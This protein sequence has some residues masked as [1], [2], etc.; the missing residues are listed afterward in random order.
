MKKWT[1]TANIV[2][3]VVMLGSILHAEAVISIV[4]KI[5]RTGGLYGDTGVN[6]IGDV[7]N[8]RSICEAN[9]TNA[10]DV[11]GCDMSSDPGY[12]DNG[13]SDETDDFYTGDLIVRTNDLIEI[14]V[15]WNATQVNNPITLSSTLPS[16]GGKNYLGWDSLPSS[17]KDGS[18]ISDDGLTLTCVRTNDASIS[19]SEDSPFQIKVKAHA[20]NGLE[21]GP[22]SFSISSD[23]LE[24]KTDDTD[25][26][27]VTVTAKPMWNIQKA[28]ISSQEKQEVDGV[29][30]YIIRYAYLL[31]ADEVAGEN[32]TASAVLGNEALGKDFSLHFT[33]DVSAVSPN[34]KLIGCSI[35]GAGGS[36]PYPWYH[37]DEPEKSVGSLEGDLHVECSQNGG[38]G[39]DITIDYSGI[40][41]SLEHVP[42]RYANGGII[43]KTRL[44]IASGVVDIFVPEEDVKNAGGIGNDSNELDTNNTLTSFDPTSISG[45]SN[46]G[47]LEESTKDNS[48]IVPLIYRGPG[49]T[50]GSFHKYFTN[51]IDASSSLPDTTMGYR[52]ADGI[53]TPNKSFAAYLT[54]SNSGNKDFNESII[55]DVMDAN[56]YDVVDLTEDNAVRILS[57][58][59]GMTPIVEYAT[60]YVAGSWPPPLDQNNAEAVVDECK[61]PGVTW[62][63]TTT[64]ARTHGPITKV[65]VSLPENAGLPGHSSLSFTINLRV[66]SKDLSDV[67]IP[68]GT[69]LVNYS[70]LHDT[71]LNED[72]ADNW[73]GASRSLNYYPDA[74]TGGNERADRAIMMRAKVR[75]V[76]ELSTTIV[77]PSDEVTVHI[78]ST[79]TTDAVDPED[80]NVKVTEMLAPGLIYVVGSGS[81]GDPAFGTCDDLE[82]DDPLKA[83]C[84]P[85]HQ[86]LI[87]DLGERTANDPLPDI[88]YNFVVSAFT[89][90]GENS[91]YTIIS[92]PTDTS[93]TSIRT[94]NKNVSVNIP[95]SLFITK[96]VNTPFREVDEAPITFTSYA[97]NGSAVDLTDIDMIDILPFNGDGGSGRG[98]GFKFTVAS[99]KVKIR[100]K[101]PTSYH[102]TLEFSKAVGAHACNAGVTWY[103]TN[104]EPNKINISPTDESNQAG[105]DT[106]WCQGTDTGPDAAC[107]YGNA[108]VTAVRLTGPDISADQTCAFEIQLTPHGNHKGDVYTNTTSAFANGVTLPTLSNHVSA[109][110]PTTLLGDFVWLDY[111]ADGKQDAD[112]PGAAGITVKLLDGTDDSELNNTVTDADGKYVFEEL[113]ADTPY[114]VQAVIPAYYTFTAQHAG[115]NK[116]KDSD[117]DQATGISDAKSLN[118][119]QQYRH[120]DIGLLST[121]TISG[122]VY[123]KV[124]NSLMGN[125]VVNLY[126]DENDDGV[127]DE[128]DTLIKSQDISGVA[129]YEFT[130][131]FDGHYLVEVDEKP[132]FSNEYALLTDEVLEADV[133]GVS[134]EDKDFMYGSRPTSD[135]KTH[136]EIINIEGKVTLEDLTGG[137]DDGTVEKYIITSLPS[138]VSGTLYL[139]DDTAV[140]AGM[141]LTPAQAQGLQ[142]DPADGFIGNALFHYTTKDDDNLTDATPAT[143]TIPVRGLHISGHVFQD[144]DNNGNVDGAGIASPSGTQLYVS[145]LENDGTLIDSIL[146]NADGSYTFTIGISPDTSYHVVLT[147]TEDATAADLPSG[148]NNADG[149]QPKNT[150]AGTDGTVDGKLTVAV[151]RADVLDNDFGINHAPTADDKSE[152]SQ[153][154]PGSDTQVTVPTLSGGDD[155]TPTGLSFTI[156]SL[157]TNAKLYYNGSEIVAADFAVADPSKLTVDPENGALSVVFQYKTTDAVGIDSDLATVTMPFT[158]L[159]LS[160]HVYDDGDHNGNINGTPINKPGGTQLHAI[161]VDAAGNVLATESVADDGTYAFGT[162][163]GIK[164]N[165]TFKVVL[166]TT[167]GTVGQPAPAASLPTGWNNA[168]GEQPD[169]P[170]NG[171]DGTPDGTLSVDVVASNVPNNDFGINHKP[172]ANDTSAP[173][174]LN[175][176]QDTQVQVPELNVTDTEDVVPDTVTIQ[177]LPGNATLYYDG[178]AV[179][180]G[181]TIAN[182]NPTK[183]KVDPVDGDQTVVFHYTTTDKAGVESDQATVTMPFEGLGISGTLF[184]DGDGDANVGGEAIAQPSGTQMHVS[185][186]GTDGKVIATHPLAADGTY[187]FTGA[188]GV[189]ANTDYTIVLSVDAG[190]PGDTAPAR[191]LP[192]AWNHTG[193]NINS[194]GA[195]NDGTVDGVIAVSLEET[196]VMQVD[197]GINEKPAANDT[198]EPMQLNPGQ[199]TQVQVPELNVTDT[200]DGA[201]TTITI[202]DLPDNATLYYDGVAATAG[203]VIADY[204][205]S[206]LTVDPIDGDQTVVF[207]Y[208]TT[209]RAG[210]ESESA[211]VTM[212]FAGLGISGTLF[213]DGDGDAN[214]NGT[215]ISQPEGEQIYVSLMGADGKVI[216]TRALAADGSYIF[217]GSESVTANTDYTLVV[218]TIAGVPGANAPVIAL[219]ANWNHTGENINSAGAGNDGVV[220]ATIDVSLGTVAVTH[221]DFGIN[222]KP[223][224]NDLTVGVQSNPAGNKHFIVPAL[225]VTD[226]EDGVPSTITIKTLPNPAAGT[227][228]YDGTPVTAGQVITDFDPAMLTVDPEE[229]NPVIT[230]SYTTTDAAGIESDMA[231]VKMP[232]LGEIHIGD[233]VWMDTNLNGAQD[234]GEE[235]V[236]G[237][238]VTL[239]DENNSVV[240][241]QTTG[242]DGKYEFVIMQPG[243]YRVEFDS[244]HY[245]TKECPPCDDAKDSN[246]H[247]ATNSTEF[248]TVDWGQTDMS[249]DAGVRPTAHI[250]DFFWIDA[251]KDGLQDADETVVAGAKVELLNENGDPVLDAEGNPMVVTTDENGKY[252]FDAPAGKKYFVRFTIPQKYIDEGYVFTANGAGSDGMNSDA[253]DDGVVT[254][255]VNAQSGGNYLTLDAGIK[256]GCDGIESDSGDALGGLM[257]LLMLLFSLF[258][259]SWMIRRE[260]EHA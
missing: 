202:Q 216:A 40:D 16:F 33:D 182:Y 20:P 144:G 211:S 160:G 53:V 138:A 102:G 128:N 156:T 230:F 145:L 204:N 178:A 76:K 5:N 186:I 43:P 64:E 180:A 47:D 193:E 232:F 150:G 237:V 140:T 235:S 148:W 149:E 70:A 147:T 134:V 213:D 112:E 17:C 55:C 258:M 212:L 25:G 248:F 18:S 19:Y 89:P 187:R 199:D 129:E 52:S 105:G 86:V 251:N 127:L 39:T 77:E 66:R 197:F 26:T 21:T 181:Q 46:F 221:V 101:L 50:S 122:K 48:V 8:G 190:V 27:G 151:E 236:S 60:G 88:E 167:A 224:A 116:K 71:V 218:S 238:T 51:D 250:G 73:V 171:T 177:D 205:A 115:S 260:A 132:G 12:N 62:Y 223:E 1:S 173:S 136:A 23:G 200:E 226:T 157:P 249:I 96:E 143:F 245:Y 162:A 133:A 41:A 103:Y 124:D 126:I 252:G 233:W 54:F 228:Y 92:A 80:S 30:G 170:G 14:V 257:G 6:T 196:G 119:N 65:R 259:G 231:T 195:G 75:T 203:Q 239:Y 99:T 135:D 158:D 175:P 183:L 104:R 61:D 85:A 7:V 208:T 97:R 35:D 123:K 155:E 222:D 107:G 152:A 79:F 32:E 227:L 93:N 242:S 36:Q 125:T 120:M 58:P 45:Q 113:E 57:K 98:K 256:C 176:G 243:K 201:P 164:T 142:F 108:E 229:G 106:E 82:A 84:T 81:I 22:I 44:P 131:V 10:N 59:D 210:I 241:T 56:L 215:A 254:V 153:L 130:N 72:A 114:K 11:P 191:T 121:L 109:F 246:V 117:V 255:P 192:A 169:N 83:T 185:L 118:L 194:A 63:S 34:A 78:E 3:M 4:T 207:H 159:I 37:A 2:L 111:D 87:W 172:V 247:G 189:T 146:V 184:D 94:S 141:E 110:V 234:A 165:T 154:N 68:S 253:G 38:A 219:P 179:V 161:L 166:S 91:T 49:Y 168:D 24:T 225:P 214:V 209:D 100:R 217:L 206:K 67:T 139:A 13:T 198:A 137:D 31:E 163:D 69:N 74:A 28:H 90:A 174:Q 29:T 9:N 240:E 42:T 188:E 244:D 220:D 95:A 15:G